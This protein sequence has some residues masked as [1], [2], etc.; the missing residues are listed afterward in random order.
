MTDPPIYQP[1]GGIYNA[2]DGM[3]YWAIH[4]NNASLPN[5]LHQR[6]GIARFN[7]RTFKAEWLLNSYNGFSF[8]G[9][10][11]ITIGPD[12]DIWFTDTD[13][14][15]VLGVSESPKQLQLAT[16]RFRPSTGEVQIMDTSL[17]Y[18]NGIAFSRDGR[19]LYIGDSGLEHYSPIPTRGPNDFY[20]YPINIEFNSTEA[21]NV[22]A[23][24]VTWVGQ[25][26][27]RRAIITRK[28]TIWQSLEGAP[29]GLKVAANGFLVVAAGLSPGVD[30]LDEVG[31]QVA[32]IQTNHAVENIQWSGRDLKTLWLVGIGGITKVQFDLAG[33]DLRN[34]YVSSQRD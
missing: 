20:N 8:A 33:P 26:L 31:S 32:R 22:V 9:P 6:P 34:Y 4:G 27:S 19:T 10:N 15:Y 2:R 28:R 25:G 13:Y 24:D 3:V 1:N 21:R 16:Y 12:G 7:P 23:W 5:G 17:Q 11:D 29:D 14:G 30:I 18:P